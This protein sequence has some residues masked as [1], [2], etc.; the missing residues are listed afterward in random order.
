MVNHRSNG[1][2]VHDMNALRAAIEPIHGW[3]QDE[4]G[5]KLYDLV[6]A[7]KLDVLELGAWCGRSTA[8]IAAA[9]EARADGH[10][11]A[12]VDTW[13]GTPGEPVHDEIM[14]ELPDGVTLFDVWSE[15]LQMLGLRERAVA[16]P[17]KTSEFEARTPWNFD[18]LL[19]D[20]DHTYE[21]VKRDFEQ[22]APRIPVGG[23]VVFD[24]V[25]TWT[26][27]T[28]F[29]REIDRKTWKLIEYWP[30]QAVFRRVA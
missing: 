4:S 11:V 13:Q 7:S 20:A 3:W 5:E 9:L 17:V 1:V 26:G 27:P 19:I 8:W 2:N 18:V 30:N 22:Y 29:H 6:R 16:H 14:K 28:K 10:F 25:P 21:A 24:D 23:H 15:N 12:S